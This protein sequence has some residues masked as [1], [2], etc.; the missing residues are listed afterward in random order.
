MR[1][2]WRDILKLDYGP[3]MTAAALGLYICATLIF[4][5]ASFY[6][7]SALRLVGVGC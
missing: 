7:V 3:K 6:A 2:F 1:A 5:I 4:A